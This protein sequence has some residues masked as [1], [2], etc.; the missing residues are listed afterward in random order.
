MATIPSS[1]RDVLAIPRSLGSP[2]RAW[3]GRPAGLSYPYTRPTH[4][5]RRESVFLMLSINELIDKFVKNN[6]MIYKS[7]LIK[8]FMNIYYYF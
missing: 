7:I 4:T 6:L 3:D 5:E 1:A 8:V 2:G